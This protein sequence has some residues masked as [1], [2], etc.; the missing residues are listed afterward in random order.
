[1]PSAAPLVSAVNSSSEKTRSR[2][3]LSHVPRRAVELFIST[4]AL[5][6]RAGLDY[7]FTFLKT[8]KVQL[9]GISCE[10]L[11]A[12]T[13][14]HTDA[15][16]G[17]LAGTTR[18]A[19]TY[20]RRRLGVRSWAQKNGKRRYQAFY[21]EREDA[22]RVF[23]HRLGCNERCFQVIDSPEKAY[24]LGFMAADGWIVTCNGE[25]NA[26]ALA[27]HERDHALLKQFAEFIG[28]RS[29]PRL[30]RPGSKL[31]QVKVSSRA[32]AEDLIS[33]GVVPRKS[34]ILELPLLPQSLYPHY[35]RGLFDGDG[36]VLVRG[37]SIAAQVTTGSQKLA[38][39][40]RDLLDKYTA[41]PCNLRLD[42]QA[43]V[44]RW[45]ADNALSLAAYMYPDGL[46]TC[47]HMERKA[48]TFFGFRG[49]GAG[50]SWEQLPSQGDSAPSR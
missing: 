6:H 19:A 3:R 36:S 30:T 2:Q 26:V 40:L 34:R 4:P 1:M 22:G 20:H 38:S 13:D 14:R 10:D 37:N 48:R 9:P 15:E 27:V 16:I 33:H 44:L 42:R 35:C 41:R 25:V 32:M 46:A 47:P 12:L 5:C 31:F 8:L 29:E 39:A 17:D 50:H 21:S 11:E 45:Y 49:S 7:L 28:F 18:T 43:W 23:S 24:W